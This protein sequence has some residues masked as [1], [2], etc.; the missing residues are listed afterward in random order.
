MIAPDAQTRLAAVVGHPVAHSLSPVIHNAAIRHAGLNAVYLAFDVRPGDLAAA[1]AGLRAAGAAGVNL[2]IPH[3]EQGLILADSVSDEARSIGATNTLVFAADG[4]EA[5]NTDVAGVRRALDALGIAARGATALVVGA[6]GAARAA[7]WALAG[8]GATAIVLVNRTAA[9]AES[10]AAE[11]SAHGLEVEA[12]EW[13]NLGAA[14]GTADVIVNATSVGMD[15]TSSPIG[16]RVLERAS[17]GGCRGVLDL[18]YGARTTPLVEAAR[19]AGLAAADGLE[20]LVHQA[21]EAF[22]LF[23]G[24]DTDATGMLAAANRATGRTAVRR[25]AGPEDMPPIV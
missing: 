4:I 11:L 7:A 17:T 6:G 2:T 19:A 21:A 23:F 10:L 18:V 15:G 20:M 1:V 5:H 25:T 16:R 22:R 24:T 13:D 8:S 12:R 14:A 9:R 3:K